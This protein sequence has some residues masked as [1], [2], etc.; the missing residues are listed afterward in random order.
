MLSYPFLLRC[1]GRWEGGGEG[2][3]KKKAV[4][5]TAFFATLWLE[6]VEEPCSEGK[7]VRD[8]VVA[9]KAAI[10]AW[11]PKIQGT[12]CPEEAAKDLEDEVLVDLKF[13]DHI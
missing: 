13:V 6:G 11:I 10:L 8:F 12:P 2:W 3:G 5:K 1:Q 7:G 9:A 4:W